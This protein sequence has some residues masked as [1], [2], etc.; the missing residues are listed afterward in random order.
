MV[1]PLL[2]NQDLTPM[3]QKLTYKQ[4]YNRNTRK[5]QVSLNLK[6]ALFLTYS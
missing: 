5:F 6:L 1:I 2:T 4:Y 3:L